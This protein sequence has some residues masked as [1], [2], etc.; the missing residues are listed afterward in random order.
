M[1]LIVKYNRYAVTFMILVFIFSS[2]GSYFLI[3]K[4]LTNELDISLLRVQ[5]RINSSIA[6]N[7]QIPKINGFD[8]EKITFERTKQPIAGNK[9][10]TVE[11]YIREQNKLHISRQLTY[12]VAIKNITYQVTITDPLEGTKHMFLAMFEITL[13]T[14]LLLIITISV[15]NRIVMKKLWSPF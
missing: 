11:T 9:L 14:I 3:K 1:R 13:I 4:A 5:A 12:S 6:L 2:V 7:Q 8:D 10:S 15:I